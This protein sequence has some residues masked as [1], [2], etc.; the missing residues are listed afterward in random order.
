MK[1]LRP[2]R[3]KSDTHLVVTI[4]FGSYKKSAERKNR[5][6]NL[7]RDDIGS[8]IFK[9]C[10]YCD[11]APSNSLK[12][13]DRP[14]IKYNGIDRKDN[15]VGYTLDNTV[16][17]C[18]KCNKT[19]SVLNSEDFIELAHMVVR[20]SLVKNTL[21]EKKLSY[22]F[23]RALASSKASPDPS[24]K[25][26]ALLIHGESGAV[27]AE[28]YNGF[29]RGAPDHKIPTTRPE[30][31]DYI[32]HA[33]TNLICN[34]A[35]HGVSTDKCVIFCTISPCIKCMRMLYQAGITEVYVAG[36]YSDFQQCSSMLDLKLIVTS[37]GQFSKIT[38]GPNL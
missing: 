1:V 8:L 34:A 11:R 19:K 35:R 23:D 36:F 7:T 15:S 10:S 6:F 20:N 3:K 29:V 33:E 31:Y 17:C 32:I 5:E 12:H 28:G 2:N 4:I 22:Y 16:T 26:G 24:T 9:N 25:V 13:K 21:S 14:V 38:I 37:I 18:W 27:I 30:K